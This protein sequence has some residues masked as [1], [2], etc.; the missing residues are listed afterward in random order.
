LASEEKIIFA[1]V[2]KKFKNKDLAAKLG[3]SG[4]LVSLVLNNKAD[5][6]GIKKETQEK[7]LALARQM[8]FFSTADTKEAAYPVEEKPG[9][10]AMIVPSFSDPFVIGITPF[11]QKAFMSI[12]VGF[13]IIIRDPDDQRF[14]RM[15]SSFRKFFS[16]LIL[17]GQVADDL[18]IRTLR[19]TNCPFIILEKSFKTGRFNTINTDIRS[20]SIAVAEHVKKLG[21]KNVVI[22]AQR[23]S[24]QSD[25]QVINELSD[26]LEYVAKTNHPEV[27]EIEKSF[28][29]NLTDFDQIEKYLRPPYRTDIFITLHSETVY[30]FMSLLRRKKI[31]IPQDVALIS[32]E[33]GIGFDLVFAPVTCL[34]KSL[35]AIS[36]KAANMVWS[37]VKNSGKG[38]FKPQVNLAPELIIRNSCG[39]ITNP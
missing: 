26:A 24:V 30:P 5:Q 11:L 36:T 9:I 25:L 6:H 33:E 4:T 39:T 1:N 38:K 31:R 20:G 12:G 16:G 17:V 34:R 18:T 19:S 27:V 22:V 35:A 8:G 3:V 29:E 14:N 21:Y 13:S 7:V 37:E 23:E 28:L 10:I 32:M 2:A 15:I